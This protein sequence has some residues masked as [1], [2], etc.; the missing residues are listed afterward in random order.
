MEEGFLISLVG[1]I[2]LG[3][4]LSLYRMSQ[5]KESYKNTNADLG[6]R[7]SHKFGHFFDMSVPEMAGFIT[8]MAGLITAIAGLIIA[9]KK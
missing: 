4:G 6:D 2:L 1:A 5:T 7:V 3:N 9:I 8:S